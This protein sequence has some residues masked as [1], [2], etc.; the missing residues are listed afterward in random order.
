VSYTVRS[1]LSGNAL[2]VDPERYR[3]T[4]DVIEGIDW[5]SSNTSTPANLEGV[6]VPT[7]LLAMTGHYWMVSAELFLEHSASTDK[8][9]VFVEGASHNI[10]PCRACESTP[11]QYGDTVKRTFDYVAGWLDRR[12]ATALGAP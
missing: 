10:T 6:H 5:H 4:E 11:G 12:F 8:Q 3:V 2:R 7:L 9:L 1:W